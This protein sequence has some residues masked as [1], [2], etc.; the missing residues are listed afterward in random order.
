MNIYVG[1]L[2]YNSTEEAL[3]EA[4]EAYG[5]TV[6]VK[7]VKDHVTGRSRGFAFVEMASKE[8]GKKAVA[9]LDGRDFNGRNLKVNEARPREQRAP[10]NNYR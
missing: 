2:P 3:K 6:S 10:R 5:E 7:L 8:A 9:E 1:N 4:F